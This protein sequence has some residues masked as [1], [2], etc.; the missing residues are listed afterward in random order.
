LILKLR[1]IKWKN[2]I[3][4]NARLSDGS[5]L[6]CLLIQNKIDLVSEEVI[7]NDI[8][9]KD[10]VKKNKFIDVFRSSAKQGIN[11]SEA[12]EFVISQIINKQESINKNT[13]TIVNERD[14][15]SIVLDSRKANN[16][17]KSKDG[18]C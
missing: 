6:P 10:F 5:L 4:E 17:E 18:C 7:K 15:R 13:D 12:M 3:D 14:K 16:K 1:T 9:I 2:S 11:V 8:E